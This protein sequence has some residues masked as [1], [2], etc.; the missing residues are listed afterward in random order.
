M[1]AAQSVITLTSFSSAPSSLRADWVVKAVLLL[2][3]LASIWSWS[4]IIEKLFRF[5]R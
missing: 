5:G 1:D 4:V 3:A 2:L